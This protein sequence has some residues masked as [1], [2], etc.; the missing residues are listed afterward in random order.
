[1]SKHTA[2]GNREKAQDL[3]RVAKITEAPVD[4]NKIAIYLSFVVIP[5]DFPDK[6]KGMV[7][8]EGDFRAI[9]VNKK[10]PLYLQRYTIGHE[11]GHFVNGHQHEDNLFIEDEAKYYTH[12]FQQE[13]DADNFSSELLMPKNFL[14]KALSTYGLDIEKLKEMYKVSEQ[15]LWIRLKNL[16]LAEKYA[17]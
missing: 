12:H 4:L 14:E 1:M 11:F 6:R 17:R 13:R 8:M 7:F 2:S 3:L 5:Y 16:R 15:A 10:H 9:G